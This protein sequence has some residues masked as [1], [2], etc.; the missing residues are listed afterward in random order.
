MSRCFYLLLI[1]ASVFWCW[2]A[3]GDEAPAPAAKPAP[4]SEHTRIRTG[5]I[6]KAEFTS[7]RPDA[8]PKSPVAKK[9]SPAWAVLTIALDP[10]RAAS[11][12]DY[13]LQ[14]DGTEYPCLDLADGED[15]F[16][17][18]LRNYSSVEGKKCRMAFAIPSANG[19]YE[20]VFKLI[21]EKGSPAKVKNK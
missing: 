12:F 20:I 3:P 7:S 1:A 17:G 9:S 8:D 21:P 14:K 11:I 5:V 2:N 16:E 18:K 6:V 19:E 10:G 15:R 4:R 13:V